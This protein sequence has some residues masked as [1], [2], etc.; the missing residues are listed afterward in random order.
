MAGA[1]APGG[2]DVPVC[3]QRVVHLVDIHVAFIRVLEVL[4]QAG[5]TALQFDV[6]KKPEAYAEEARAVAERTQKAVQT[7]IDNGLKVHSNAH[8]YVERQFTPK[9]LVGSLRDIVVQ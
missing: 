5:T 4:E 8:V 6:S 1:G 3:R 9:H 2:R 7:E